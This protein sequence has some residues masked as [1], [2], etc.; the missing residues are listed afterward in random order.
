MRLMAEFSRWQLRMALGLPKPSIGLSIRAVMHLNHSKAE[1][2][3]SSCQSGARTR[4]ISASSASE[5]LGVGS[6]GALPVDTG[7]GEKG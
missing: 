5:L 2:S 4:R 6:V 1:F 3:V 7:L